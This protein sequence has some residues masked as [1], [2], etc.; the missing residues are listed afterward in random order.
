[1]TS[2]FAVRVAQ[3]RSISRGVGSLKSPWF[4]DWAIIRR[5]SQGEFRRTWRPAARDFNGHAARL[6]ARCS[7]RHARRTTRCSNLRRAATRRNRRAAFGKQQRARFEPP[8]DPVAWRSILRRARREKP[9][10]FRLKRPSSGHLEANLQPTMIVARCGESASASGARAVPPSG[11]CRSAV[12][13]DFRFRG[14]L[15]CRRP[16]H[17][18]SKR[19]S[20]RP[21]W[22]WPPRPRN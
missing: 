1:M 7:H 13:S 9:V 11:R 16:F 6:R 5:S 18:S 15:R 8:G 3:L 4:A 12:Q 21:R 22:R 14:I 10:H 17:G 20:L 19:S 2:L